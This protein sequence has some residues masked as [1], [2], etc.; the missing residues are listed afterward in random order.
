MTH[1]PGKTIQGKSLLQDIE[2]W[3]LQ[4]PIAP[5]ALATT[6]SNALQRLKLEVAEREAKL[7]DEHPYT[8]QSINNLVRCLKMQG[9][10]LLAERY[11][12]GSAADVV[13]DISNQMDP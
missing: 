11:E 3:A 7:G 12:S 2:V 1:G 4:C 6:R 10:E 9:K 13:D 5:M 8:L